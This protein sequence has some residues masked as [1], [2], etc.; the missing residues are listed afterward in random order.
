[1][2]ETAYDYIS[3]DSVRCVCGSC[4]P[5]G[6]RGSAFTSQKNYNIQNNI[7]RN[8]LHTFIVKFFGFLFLCQILAGLLYLIWAFCF[9]RALCYC[10]F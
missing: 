9:S 5:E 4:S 6:N 3:H 8:V 1:M 7:Q 2:E 10:V